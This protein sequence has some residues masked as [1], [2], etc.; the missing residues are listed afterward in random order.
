M[1]ISER[2]FKPKKKLNDNHLLININFLM[3]IYRQIIEDIKK[4]LP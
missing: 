4:K 1:I 3:Q 2:N